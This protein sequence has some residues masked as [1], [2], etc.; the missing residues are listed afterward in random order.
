MNATVEAARRLRGAIEAA[1]PEMDVLRSLPQTLAEA[2]AAEDLHR[3]CVPKGLGGLEVSVRT[4]VETLEALAEA[5]A[6][7][8]WCTMIGATTG[9]LA[10]WM[11]TD[12]ARAIF[13]G[14]GLLFAGV[15][16]PF[17]VA[18]DTGAGY[19]VSGRWSWNSGGRNA[20]WLCGGCT[21]RRDNALVTT[22]DGR[23]EHK[24]I[25]FPASAARFHDTWRTSGLMGTGSGDMSVD[26]YEAPHP[27]AVSLTSGAPMIDSPL[28][29][30]PVFG[31]LAIG[32]AAVALG[33]ARGAL[34]AF[35]HL[36]STKRQAGGRKLAER[37]TVQA[38][39]AEASAQLSSARA[40]LMSEI[41]AAWVLAQ[42]SRPDT[43][44]RARLRL[45]ATHLT[46]T[47]AEVARTLQDLAGGAGVFLSEPLHRRSMDAQTM[48]AHIMV[49]PPTL[50]V[51]GR[52]LLGLPGEPV[53]L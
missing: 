12:A 41:D 10:A 24:L 21:V 4:L 7:A 2:M 29:R 6:S 38:R 30:F 51:T 27:H 48:T 35:A 9:A 20:A 28:Y 14:K 15:Y 1:R 52:V 44:T 18:E 25:F 49:A 34:E 11:A 47:A 3:L 40:F 19:R 45:A 8:A 32:I 17:G 31:L 53:E 46:R 5:D 50:E 26:G 33:N 37:S 22:P 43:A 36:A 23:P 13:G 42:T 39:Y 16:A